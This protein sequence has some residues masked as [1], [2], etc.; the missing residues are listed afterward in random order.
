MNEKLDP[1][2]IARIKK[3]ARSARIRQIRRK[4]AVT[5]ATLVAL[6]SGVILVRSQF[7]GSGE[8]GAAQ[9]TLVSRTEPNPPTTD[10]VVGYEDYDDSDDHGDDDD[11]DDHGDDY[12]SDDHGDDDDFDEYEEDHDSDDDGNHEGILGTITGAAAGII[13]GD[14]SGSQSQDPGRSAEPSRSPAPLTTSQS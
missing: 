7:D 14:S 3:L 13:R 12:D 10:N 1:K 4:T 9:T 6:F 11:F 2:E 5:A 8:A